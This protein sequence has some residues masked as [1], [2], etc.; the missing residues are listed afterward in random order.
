ML[1]LPHDFL[2]IIQFTM[3]ILSFQYLTNHSGF[4]DLS[5]SKYYLD[6][7]PLFDR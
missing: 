4:S 5:G 1:S 2:N 3:V 7:L 6:E